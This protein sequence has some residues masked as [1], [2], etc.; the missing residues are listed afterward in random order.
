MVAPTWVT[1]QVLAAA[2][3]NS[4]FVPLVAYKNADQSVTSSTTLVND[5][6]L[7]LTISAGANYLMH[8]YLDYEAANS[9]GDI[10]RGFTLPATTFIR[11]MP[12]VRN[13]SSAVVG[14]DTS[15]GSGTD[16]GGG[17]GAG[18][19]R[20]ALLTGTVQCG[21]TGTLQLQWAQNTSSATSTIVHAQ[22]ALMLWRI[23]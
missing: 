19:L 15:I 16:V 5:S 7:H 9:P 13:T 11:Y 17:G 1:G 10:K 23:G 6:A 8:C 12:S 18:V 2:D 4:W 21:T 22:S 3:V 20:A 14:G